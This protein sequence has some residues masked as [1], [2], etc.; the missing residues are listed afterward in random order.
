MGFY[1][2]TD[3]VAAGKDTTKTTMKITASEAHVPCRITRVV[4]ADCDRRC[5]TP[6]IGPVARSSRPAG[7][8]ARP[9]ASPNSRSTAVWYATERYCV[10]VIIVLG[11]CFVAATNDRVSSASIKRS[12]LLS[13]CSLY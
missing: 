4:A 12:H 10:T 13:E 8:G 7:A 3:D 6:S 5:G 9:Q 1:V 2:R 11:E